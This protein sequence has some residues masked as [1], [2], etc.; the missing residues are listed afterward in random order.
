MESRWQAAALAGAGRDPL[1]S[2][3]RLERRDEGEEEVALEPALVQGVWVAVGGRY[4]YQ[5]VL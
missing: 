2:L 5:A 4:Q 3:A 1:P